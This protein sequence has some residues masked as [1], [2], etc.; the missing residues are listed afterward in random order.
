MTLQLK[1]APTALRL[2][3]RPL[4]RPPLLF[5][6]PHPPQQILLLPLLPHRLRLLFLLPQT[7]SR[8]RRRCREPFST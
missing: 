2:S 8:S 3:L 6:H 1:N 4:L 5:L 7:D